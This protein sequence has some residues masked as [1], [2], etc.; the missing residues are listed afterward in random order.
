MSYFCKIAWNRV[1]FYLPLY[2][3]LAW[4][5]LYRGLNAPVLVST[6]TIHIVAK[7]W[8]YR[9]ATSEYQWFIENAWYVGWFL[10]NIL[11]DIMVVRLL[12]SAMVNPVKR[13]SDLYTLTESAY[14]GKRL[15]NICEISIFLWSTVTMSQ[16]K[17]VNFHLLQ[18]NT[19]KIATDA[20][21][22]SVWK[23][24]L[25]CRYRRSFYRDF[26]TDWKKTITRILDPP[27]HTRSKLYLI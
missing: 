22:G 11:W 6:L 9:V 26:H 8:R 12:P 10:K 24:K 19:G 17:S 27:P 18:V 20:W 5:S 13:P 2:F 16:T 25:A 21:F 15:W 3:A 1:I 14:A 7:C 4:A 23:P